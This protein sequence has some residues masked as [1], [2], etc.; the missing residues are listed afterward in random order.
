MN[1]VRAYSCFVNN[2][3][4][5]GN[6]YTSRPQMFLYL[7]ICNNFPI[8]FLFTFSIIHILIH[9]YNIIQVYNHFLSLQPPLQI[10]IISLTL[11]V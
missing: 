10:F 1:A 7:L 2:S 6:V 3:L 9:D 5:V 8:F 11:S 4:C